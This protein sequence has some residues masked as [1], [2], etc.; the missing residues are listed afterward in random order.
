MG[1]AVGFF[2]LAVGFGCGRDDSARSETAVGDEPAVA[3]DRIDED[4][5]R[6]DDATILV[7]GDSLAAGYGL[8]DI[9]LSWPFVLESMLREDGADVSVV[10]GAESGRT[11][12]G[13]ASAI[14]WYLRRPVD[15]LIIALGGNDGLRGVRV[16]AVEKNLETMV[17]K[18]LEKNPGCRVVIAGMRAPPSQGADYCTEFE[19]VF[20]RVAERHGAALVPFLLEGVAAEPGL[21]QRDGIHPTAEGQRILAKNVFRVL[22]PLLEE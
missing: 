16:D 1:A 12:A 6:S 20:V 5:D 15:V 10:N 8:G 19:A 11:T 7:V 4:T 18:T 21:N 22:A 14:D 17:T 3:S 2:A 13:G 9:A